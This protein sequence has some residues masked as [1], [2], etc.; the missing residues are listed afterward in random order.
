L[1]VYTAV[2]SSSALGTSYGPVR[3]VVAL[4]ITAGEDDAYAPPSISIRARTLTSLPSR[5]AP[6]RIQILDG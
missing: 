2:P 3:N 5:F 4:A 1:F 6:M